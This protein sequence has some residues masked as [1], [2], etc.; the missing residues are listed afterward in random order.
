MEVFADADYARKAADR[1]SVSEGLVMW[2]GGCISWLSRTQKCVTLSTTEAE[3]VSLADVMKKEVLFLRKVWRF[4]LPEAGMPCIPVFEDNQ[5][6]IQLAQNPISNSNSKHIDVRH[7]FIRELVGRKGI[8][9]FHVES[10]Y[11]HAGF[12]T[13]A[14]HVGNFEFHRNFAMSV[15]QER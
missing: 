1:R 8:S 11:Q 13:K 12:L 7:H 4:M 6:A 10:A 3:Y 5:G 14:F 2:G 15:G 9:I